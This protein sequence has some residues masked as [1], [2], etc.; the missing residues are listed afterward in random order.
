MR[1]APRPARVAICTPTVAHSSSRGLLKFKFVRL[2]RE[3]SF[4]FRD[5]CTVE[6]KRALWSPGQAMWPLAPRSSRARAL[7]LGVLV[8]QNV[9]AGLQLSLATATAASACATALTKSVCT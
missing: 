7:L 2:K 6:E 8:L 1:R 4:L 5:L 3:G 9:S